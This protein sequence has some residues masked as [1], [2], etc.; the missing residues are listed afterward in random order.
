MS[1]ERPVNFRPSGRRAVPGLDEALPLVRGARTAV[2]DARRLLARAG[3][4]EP[5][6]IQV[7]AQIE[8]VLER[9]ERLHRVRSLR[10]SD[11]A[12]LELC[13]DPKGCRLPRLT[14]EILILGSRGLLVAQD[15]GD[16][17]LPYQL[18]LTPDGIAALAAWREDPGTR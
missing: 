13:E 16:P 4:P 12:V 10:P 17:N 11:I 14:G 8:I 5:D 18:T 7:T 2:E 9:L 6:L 3:T 15:N 1:Q